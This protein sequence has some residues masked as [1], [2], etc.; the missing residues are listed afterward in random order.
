MRR[1]QQHEIDVPLLLRDIRGGNFAREM[2]ADPFIDPRQVLHP[3]S[4]N[5]GKDEELVLGEE[6]WHLLDPRESRREAHLPKRALSKSEQF[7]VECGGGHAA[8]AGTS[9]ELIRL[10]SRKRTRPAVVASI[11][12]SPA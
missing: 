9:P 12:S 1:R 5:H 8:R 11:R 10:A 2:Q 7:I 3:S 6:A 4:A